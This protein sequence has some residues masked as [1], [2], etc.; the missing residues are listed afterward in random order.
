VCTYADFVNTTPFTQASILARRLGA[1]AR[2]EEGAAIAI[3]TH[4]ACACIVSGVDTVTASYRHTGASSAS[5]NITA[6]NRSSEHFIDTRYTKTS[7]VVLYLT[8]HCRVIP[9]K[10]HD[11]CI[12]TSL[13]EN[14]L[15][16]CLFECELQTMSQNK[17]HMLG[18]RK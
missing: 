1:V 13:K 11:Y 14:Q 7:P 2:I 5:F 16:T 8:K 12:Y 15:I 6:C 10:K 3:V 4:E 17:R 18:N 9:R